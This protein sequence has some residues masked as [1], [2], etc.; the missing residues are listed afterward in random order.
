[1]IKADNNYIHSD[2]TDKIIGCAYEVY[3]QLGHG[4]T[5]KVYLV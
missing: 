4:F 1:M 5:E 2:L 3:K